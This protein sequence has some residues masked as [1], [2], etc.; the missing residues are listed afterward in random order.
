[1]KNRGTTQP[2]GPPEPENQ[3]E[4]K[5]PTK[6]PN[7]LETYR[8]LVKCGFVPKQAYNLLGDGKAEPQPDVIAELSYDERQALTVFVKKLR[9][10]N[11]PLTEP[12]LIV[13]VIGLDMILSMSERKVAEEKKR[14]QWLRRRDSL[15]NQGKVAFVL[16]ELTSR[17]SSYTPSFQREVLETVLNG[18]PLDPNYKT[19]DKAYLVMRVGQYFEGCDDSFCQA[20]IKQY[21]IDVLPLL[22]IEH[23][24]VVEDQKRTDKMFDAWSKLT[25]AQQDVVLEALLKDIDQEGGA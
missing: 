15:I 14:E 17:L 10:K 1:M 16:E 6:P 8:V 3:A 19:T 22:E 20:V 2:N 13:S 9:S 12:S 24:Q 25:E 18:K 7:H 4:T 21:L 5:P 23:Q 11:I